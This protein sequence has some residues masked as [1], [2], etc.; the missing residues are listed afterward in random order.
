MANPN[1]TRKT[2]TLGQQCNIIADIY[3]QYFDDVKRFF[4][5]YT[6][7]AMMAEDMTQDLFVRLMNFEQMI[8]PSTAKSFVFTIARRMVVDDARHQQFVRRATKGFLMKME[9]ERFWQ[10]AETL[11]CKQLR[12]ME[13]EALS[14]LPKKMAQVYRLTRFEEKTAQEL[15]Q[16]LSISKRTVEY[17]LL[18][19]RRE[20][21]SMLKKAINF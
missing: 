15:A 12:Q 16:E 21:R 14:R 3:Q 6:H 2:S 9:E 4:L 8:V 13:Q 7:E 18:V 19:S 1:D 17:H 10:D 20:I 5:A 11:E